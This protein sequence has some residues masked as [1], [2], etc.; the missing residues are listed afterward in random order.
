MVAMETTRFLLACLGGDAERARAAFANGVDLEDLALLALRHEVMGELAV[1]IDTAEIPL[2]DEMAAAI[3]VF[4]QRQEEFQLVLRR[5]TLTL[6]RLFQLH[7]IDVFFAK[8]VVWQALLRPADVVRTAKDVDVYLR[9]QDV[10]RSLN[11][12]RQAY[13]AEDRLPLD[14][15]RSHLHHHSVWLPKDEVTVELHWEVAAPWHLLRFD[16]GDALARRTT[17]LVEGQPLETLAAVDAIVFTALELSKDSWVSLKKILD[18]CACVDAAGETD[19]AAAL[20]RAGTERSARALAI[21]SLVASEL[22]FLKLTPRLR[23]WAHRQGGADLVGAACVRQI[24]DPWGSRAPYQ[25]ARR[26]LVMA[27]KHDQVVKRLYHPW[28]IILLY[29]LR[30]WLGRPDWGR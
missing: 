20:K 12:L 7:D 29:R 22:G 5:R 10:P 1:A 16:I 8:G 2:P 15:T 19:V 11:V 27:M 28:R 21:S 23:D 18:F 17:T 24:V 6:S 25:R 4:L 13:A 30:G 9:A 26:G 3:R 14:T